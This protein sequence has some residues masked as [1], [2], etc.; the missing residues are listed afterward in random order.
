M[1]K[2]ERVAI[3]TGS[4]SGLGFSIA[5]KLVESGYIVYAGMRDLTKASQLEES[6]GHSP[7]LHTSYLDLLDDLSIKAI[8]QKATENHGGVD[9]LINN[10]A[11]ALLGPP[12]SATSV[13]VEQLFRVNVFA[14]IKLVQLVL[15][16]MRKRKQ[17]HIF[18]VGS[19][20]SIES[21]GYLGVYAAT[22]FAQE[23]LMLS[24]ATVLQKWNIQCTM[25]EP[26]AMN[27]NL[28]Q[29]IPVGS[30]YKNTEEDPYAYFNSNALQF[31]KSVLATGKNP[32]EVADQVIQILRDSQNQFRY[33]TCDFSQSLL[34]RH[35]RD[36][37]GQSWIE[38]HRDFIE[39]FY[40]KL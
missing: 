24:W 20:S 33:P 10:A 7:L 23:A 11:S 27:T 18:N 39:Q 6:C 19:I 22:K 2:I 3:V 1:T 31:L 37:G 29:T 14:L 9:L 12:D 5:K 35:L 17:G 21:C 28:P 15:P 30:F 32:D 40:R 34:S 16:S 26:G 38:E 25:L 4:S 36:P 13:E 8:V